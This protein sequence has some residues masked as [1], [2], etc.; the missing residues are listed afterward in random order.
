MVLLD[1][2][3]FHTFKSILNASRI[4]KTKINFNDEW[5]KNVL[6][7]IHTWYW[8]M[9]SLPN[10][11]LELTKLFYHVHKQLLKV[12]LSIFDSW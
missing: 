7:L 2:L 12:L 6:E 9:W 5:A 8:F 11:F 10:K 1:P 4:K 3:I